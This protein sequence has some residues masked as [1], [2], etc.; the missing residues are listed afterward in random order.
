MNENRDSFLSGI[1]ATSAQ[2]NIGLPG[3]VSNLST[4]DN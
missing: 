3:I 4:R 2:T 1:D